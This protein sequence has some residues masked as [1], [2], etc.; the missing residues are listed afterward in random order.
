MAS[1]KELI[2]WQK[3]MDLCIK[4]YK[5]TENYPKNE[6]YG[7]TLQ[8]RKCSVS[9]PSNI[10]EGQRRG[11]KAEFVQFLRISYGSAAELET[12]LIIALK[13]GYLSQEK[14]D[15]LNNLL[16]E[17]LSMLY[18]LINKNIL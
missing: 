8:S 7:L 18:K 2:V 6:Q 5:T 9:I 12:Q 16:Q 11:H 17:I 1:Y 10:A 4:V 15:E 3:S 13:I 14:F